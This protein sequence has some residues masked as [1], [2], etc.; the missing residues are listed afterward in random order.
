M[1]SDEISH[2][3]HYD[4][5]SGVECRDVIAVMTHGMTGDMAFYTGSIIKYLYRFRFKGVPL[6][7]LKK[8]RQYID[9]L[10]E[11]EEGK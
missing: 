1:K 4:N 11:C 8:T 3:K 2:P 7:D 5:G 6:K 9:F 10:I